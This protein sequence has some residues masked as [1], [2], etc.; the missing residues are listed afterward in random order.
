[1]S[2]TARRR[3]G[4][5]GEKL[6]D[7]LSARY[8]WWRCERCESAGEQ[9]RLLLLEA[10]FREIHEQ[11]FQAASLSRILKDTG[12][13]K[14]ALY[15]HFPNKQALG[16]AVV[17]EIIATTLRERWV[18]PMQEA[19]DPIVTFITLLQEEGKQI[20]E[21]M[22][23]LGCPLN[24]LS[25]EMSPIDAGFKSR[26]ESIYDE[27]REAIAQALRRG[28]GHG[29]VRPSVNVEKAAIFIVASLEGCLG[30]A[31]VAQSIDVL[32]ACGTGLIHYLKS[33]HT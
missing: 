26:L 2:T 27:W 15:H 1:M 19:N 12:V 7:V 8:H 11:G 14:G 21:E 32:H 25:Q 33:L 20:D 10:A 16:Y 5:I 28:Q 22:V 4:R 23:R 30:S 31:K 13:T 6:H 24:N 3:H 18:K 29:Q 17:D 9:T